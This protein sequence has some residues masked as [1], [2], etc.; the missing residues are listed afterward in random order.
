[1]SILTEL[2]GFAMERKKWWLFPTILV[3]LLVGLLIFLSGVSS[4]V[5]FT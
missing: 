4:V 3:L 5:P 1:M 2:W